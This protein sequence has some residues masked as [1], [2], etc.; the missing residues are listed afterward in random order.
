MCGGFPVSAHG[1]PIRTVVRCRF[2]VWRRPQESTRNG[3][4]SG[5]SLKAELRA[6]PSSG[7]GDPI[8]LPHDCRRRTG[9]PDPARH[10]GP[11]SDFFASL[12]RRS[13]RFAAARIRSD[14]RCFTTWSRAS[15]TAR[16]FPVNPQARAIHSLKCYPTLA[17]IPDP[18]DLAV[19]MV[20]RKL[21]QGVIEE[22]IA[23]GVRGLVVITAGFSR[24]RRGGGAARA[25]SA[26]DGARGR[27]PHDRSELHGGDQHRRG[28]A[29]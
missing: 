20:P 3:N 12:D 11:R 28:G 24:D 18:V 16:S 5:S 13:R 7:P 10:P 8:S 23:K 4:R 14:L 15:S 2:H 9:N 22:C 27:R 26:R 17:A 19:V 29:A 6:G 21:V 1:S 25:G